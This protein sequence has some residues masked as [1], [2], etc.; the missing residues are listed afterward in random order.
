[1]ESRRPS[2]AHPQAPK[3][4]SRKPK[5]GYLSVLYSAPQPWP[6][7]RLHPHPLHQSLTAAP[8]GRRELACS[9]LASVFSACSESAGLLALAACPGKE[10]AACVRVI[11][12]HEINPPVGCGIREPAQM[13]RGS[14]F[15]G[16]MSNKSHLSLTLES[17][18]FC[19][20]I[21]SDYRL[22]AG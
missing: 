7:P 18:I 19:Q 17:D 4:Y 12:A 1:M 5:L 22:Q 10:P 6:P 9:L 15:Y 16:P 20:Q 3:L 8:S 14:Q 21:R 11:S 2:D 13:C